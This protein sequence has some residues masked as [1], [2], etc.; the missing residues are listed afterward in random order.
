MRRGKLIDANAADPS[1]LLS[2]LRIAHETRQVLAA[3]TASYTM[4]AANLPAPKY[5]D[6]TEPLVLETSDWPN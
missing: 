5:G 6:I 2:I 3:L 4:S 1:E